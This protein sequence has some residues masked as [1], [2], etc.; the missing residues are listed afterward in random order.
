MFLLAKNLKPKT[1]TTLRIFS[2][3]SDVVYFFSETG[4]PRYQEWNSHFD[5]P[6]NKGKNNVTHA[7]KDCMGIFYCNGF[8]FYR[9]FSYVGET[10]S[11]D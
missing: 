4:T 3:S 6:P 11:G 1:K 10:Y 7:H 2:K 9:A 5:F 8:S